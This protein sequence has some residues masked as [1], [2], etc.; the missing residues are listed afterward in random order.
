MTDHL[1]NVYTLFRDSYPGVAAALDGV[2][3]AVDSS[4]PLDAKTMRLVKLAIAIGASADGAVRSN[5]RK[6]T[7]V[8]AT[9]QEIRQVAV[10]AIT[11]IGFPASIAAVGWIDQVLD[12]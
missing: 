1:P 10:A 11:T 8:G 12:T 9:P 2:G 3:T 5:V 7:A 6:A 4:G